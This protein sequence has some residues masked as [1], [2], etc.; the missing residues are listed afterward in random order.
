MASRVL[1]AALLL[2]AVA[3][4]F[5]APLLHTDSPRA[6]S[7]QYI[8][9]LRSELSA[10]Q[11][12]AHYLKL[13]KLI[14]AHNDTEIIHTYADVFHGYA[15]KTNE[16]VIT[17]LRSLDDVEFVEID[18]TVSIAACAQQSNAIWGL[19]RI[20]QVAINLNGLYNY[21]S[22]SGAGIDAYIVDTGILTTHTEFSGRATWG[23]NKADTTNT[24]CNGHGT[25]VAGTVGGTLYGV[26]K[27][28]NLIAVK[29]LDCDGSGTNAGVIAG[30]D[31][32][33]SNAKKFT[34]RAVANMSLGGGKSTAL[35]TA[36]ANAVK[37]NIPFAVAAGNENQDA[38]NTSPASELSAISVG[39]TVIEASGG[40]N[41]DYRT[42]FSNYGSCVT[43][44]A[45]GELI[46][47]AWIG[48]NTATL[49]ISGTSM[50]SPHVAGVAALQ[51]SAN[52]TATAAQIKTYIV[53]N[54]TSNVIN[55]VC[56][57]TACN[58][59]PNKMLYIK[60]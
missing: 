51:L 29:V 44:F 54:A 24:D 49:T 8:V 60:C 58:K 15:L 21:P 10:D 33:S 43:L 57:T 39:A 46:K 31:W 6:I 4:A 20:S 11:L 16:K 34:R 17:Q 13:N 36:V 55:M 7:G 2:V 50:A 14:S 56:T 28:V 27:K 9:I 53:N 35:N 12:G 1:L 42:D 41:A 19:N 32:V 38:C 25:H 22:D 47:S 45:P 52:P 3:F 48:S 26:A 18:Q 37:A 30:V 5:Q 23:I 59:S 40:K